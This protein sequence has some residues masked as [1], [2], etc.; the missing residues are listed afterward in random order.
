MLISLCACSGDD[1]RRSDRKAEL[2]YPSS[3]PTAESN[4][5]ISE[6]DDAFSGLPDSFEVISKLPELPDHIKNNPSF[7]AS[8]LQNMIAVYYT[9]IMNGKINSD[10]FTPKYSSDVLPPPDADANARKNAMNNCTIGGALEYNAGD[11]ENYLRYHETFNGCLPYFCYDRDANIY[12]VSN[13]KKDNFYLLTSFEQNLYFIFKYARQEKVQHDAQV[14]A[15][16]ELTSVVK[17]YYQGIKNGTV[18]NTVKLAH[19]NDVLPDKDADQE[20]RS[21]LASKATITGALDHGKL[22]TPLYPLVTTI[23]FSRKARV[24]TPLDSTY[25]DAAAI[26][27]PDMNLGELYN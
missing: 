20:I 27:S 4:D 8:M 17:A 25:P 6:T 3:Q 13:E 19:A 18:N 22:Y 21:D 23:G 9:G 5:E 7:Y 26:T 14:Y 15:A 10:T 16:S 12:P 24:F 1:N 2:T 11:H